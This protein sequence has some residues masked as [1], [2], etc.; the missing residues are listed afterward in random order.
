MKVAITGVGSW[1]SSLGWMPHSHLEYG[2][3]SSSMATY[4]KR[5]PQWRLGMFGLRED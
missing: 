1:Q 4:A 5:D 2:T 3:Y